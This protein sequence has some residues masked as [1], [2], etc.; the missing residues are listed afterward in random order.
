MSTL[1]ELIQKSPVHERK[2]EVRTYPLENSQVVVEGWLR[3]ER[4]V[5]GFHRDGSPRPPGVV[6]LMGVRLLLGDF[7]VTIL[8]AE[9]EMATIPHELCPTV[10]DSIKKIIGLPIISGFSDEVRKRLGGVE[11]CSHLM[12]L[13][14]AMAPAALHGYWAH[15]SR[16]PQPVPRSFDEIPGLPYLLNSCRLWK[17]DGPLIRQIKVMFEKQGSKNDEE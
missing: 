17:E 1:K 11:G 16:E 13:V 2:L 10:A 7:P 14:L 9:A 8:E 3:D 15:L 12:H 5:F 6:H 4:L